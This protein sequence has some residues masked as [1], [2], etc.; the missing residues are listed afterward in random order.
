MMMEN[1]PAVYR[2]ITTARVENQEDRCL[3]GQPNELRGEA[4]DDLDDNS[5]HRVVEQSPI[6]AHSFLKV[7]TR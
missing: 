6:I 2:E 7:E 1:Q 3:A 5:L 4:S